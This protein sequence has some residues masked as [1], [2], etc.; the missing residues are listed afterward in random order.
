MFMFITQMVAF[1]LLRVFTRGRWVVKKGENS[2]YIVIE[3][4]LSLNNLFRTNH[5][6]TYYIHSLYILQESVRDV[7]TKLMDYLNTT[8]RPTNHTRKC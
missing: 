2:V 6:R 5:T 3:W 8:L 4:P 1:S 7:S